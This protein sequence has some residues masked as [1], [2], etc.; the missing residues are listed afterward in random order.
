MNARFDI[1][2]LE[3]IPLPA[4]F[5]DADARV[6]GANERAIAIQP[7]ARQD[8]PLVLV[9]RHPG[10]RTAVENCLQ[11]KT[12]QQTVYHHSEGPQEYRFDVSCASVKDGDGYGALVC[13]RDVSEVQQ[14]DQM[15]RD[16]IANVSHELRTPLTAILGFIETLQGPARDDP[17]AQARFLNI[18]SAEASR[19]NRLVGD[20]LS[21]SKVVEVSRM[22][23]TSMVDID[24]IIRT[25]LRNLTPLAEDA[26]STLSYEAPTAGIEI[27]GDADQLM[28]VVT[29]L[30]ENAIKYGGAN[31][32]IQISLTETDRDRG[33]RGPAV[34]LNVADN[35]PGID[36]IH[37]PRLTERFYRIDSHRSRE[38]GGTGLGLAIVKHIINRHRGRFSISSELGKG[39][40]FRVVLPKS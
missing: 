27:P 16:F 5:V 28:Q 19:M 33:V 14:L 40:E 35:G 39:S 30:L 9:F 26:S 34:V 12:S 32:E 15:R 8:L 36:Q 10:L 13:F 31:T 6:A 37:I 38:M 3:A 7:R 1:S 20:L 24:G 18:M 4:L 11:S 2:T 23:P 25:A 21:L 29:N 17:A 22:R